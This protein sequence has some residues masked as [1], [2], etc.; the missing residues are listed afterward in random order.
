MHAT[1]LSG[2]TR[3]GIAISALWLGASAWLA[4]FPWPL[5]LLNAWMTTNTP[6]PEDPLGL[7]TR[8]LWSR[9]FGFAFLPI[10]GLW[11]LGAVAAWVRSGFEARWSNPLTDTGRLADVLALIQVLAMSKFSY[12]S[13]Q[14]LQ[15]DLQGPPRS[16]KSWMAVAK[17]H[18]E[19]FR[20]NSDSSTPVSL[21]ARHVA[22]NDDGEPKALPPGYVSELLGLAIDLHD[23][24]IKRA[25]A[26]ELVLPFGVA[27]VGGTLGMLAALLRP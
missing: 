22:P 13:E 2:W 3:L 18:P 8:L 5:P 4:A 15:T 10:A 17:E 11:V 20:A 26:W 6:V 25:R 9:V 1:S 23:R 12:R 19:L 14:N 24:Q 7:F 27:I 16:A 21:I